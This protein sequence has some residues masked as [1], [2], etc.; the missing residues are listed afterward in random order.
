M[1]QTVGKFQ[2]KHYST[3][4]YIYAVHVCFFSLT[5]SFYI[6]DVVLVLVQ[7]VLHFLLVNLRIR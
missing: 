6:C 4:L 2:D 1:L 7:Q 5:I 3:K